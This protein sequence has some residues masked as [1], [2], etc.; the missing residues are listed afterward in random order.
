MTQIPVSLEHTALLLIDMHR[1]HLDP[2]VATLPVDATWA[3]E[4][5]ANTKTLLQGLRAIDMNVIHVTTRY[6]ANKQ[7]MPVDTYSNANPYYR[8]RSE[9]GK[10]KVIQKAARWH[11]IEGSVQTQFMPE[12]QPL[13]G[14]H[15]VVKKR[16]SAFHN[17]DLDL[18]LRCLQIN[19]L[20]VAGVNTNN[21]I[22]ATTIDGCVRDYGMIVVSDCVASSYGKHMHKIA[23]DL[24]ENTFGW[25]MTS[26]EVLD[27]MRSSK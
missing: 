19:T 4:I 9:T 24:I 16:Y 7:G 6:R 8:W 10:V 1:G 26:K 3:A 23:L 17:T 12:V 14:E 2:E 20:I 22:T 25:V 15:V 18:L 13:P 11:N 27:L 5:L 21:C